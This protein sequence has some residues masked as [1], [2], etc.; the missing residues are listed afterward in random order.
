MLQTF[1]NLQ[2][3]FG[4]DNEGATT[5][6]FMIA[7]PLIIF[8]MAGSFTIFDAYAE[9]TRA[10]KATYTVADILSRQLEV[11]DDYIDDMNQLFANFM[12]ESTNDVWVRV[13]S[14]EKIDDDL[15]IDWS[16]AT[17]LHNPLQLV[18]EIPDELIPNIINDE[19]VILVES[20]TSFI[21]FL[22]YIGIEARTY[23]NIVVVSPRFSSQLANT[24]S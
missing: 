1:K 14:I 8:W 5:V 22:D 15:T 18:S 16:T 6:E 4:R 7:M 11:D 19:S 2:A 17:G 23:S 21:P 13:S 10:M 3:K 24:S 20:Y 12:G 9:S